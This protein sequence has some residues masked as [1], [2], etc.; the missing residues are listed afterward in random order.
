MKTAADVYAAHVVTELCAR[1]M[2]RPRA[3][4]LVQ[5]HER[6]VRHAFVRG[7]PASYVASKLS[8]TTKSA[9][10]EIVG[11]ASGKARSDMRG[12]AVGSSK[13]SDFKIRRSMLGPAGHAALNADVMVAGKRHGYATGSTECKIDPKWQPAIFGEDLS[14]EALEKLEERMVSKAEYHDFISALKRY[15]RV[16]QYFLNAKKTLS[17]QRMPGALYVE[18]TGNTKVI[19]GPN[20][21]A[22]RKEDKKFAAATYASISSSC[23][24]ECHLRDNGCYAQQG[25]TSMTIK[26]LD[27]EAKEY[28]L[29]S[30]DTAASEAYS[31]FTSHGGGRVDAGGAKGYLRVHV[32]GDSQTVPGTHMIAESVADWIHRGGVQAWCYTHA[33]RKVPRAAWGPISTLASLDDPATEIEAAK[34]QGYVPAI[35]VDSFGPLTTVLPNGR[36]PVLRKDGQVMM[37]KGKVVTEAAYKVEDYD[38]FQRQYLARRAH[39]PWEGD[40]TGTKYIPCPAQVEE[41]VLTKKEY[42]QGVDPKLGEKAGKGCLDCRLCFNDQ[43][44]LRKNNL[45]IMFEAHGPKSKLALTVLNDFRGPRDTGE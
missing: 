5:S 16:H 7:T 24:D 22:R 11:I 36:R 35:V 32:G 20:Y 30:I 9:G 26:R 2:S 28:H 34:A 39:R 15:P 12:Y 1:G 23:P 25:K 14:E 41:F 21:V 6:E 3:V 42:E 19:G 13:A 29:N 31:I 10:K 40:K 18:D 38:A 33:W 44:F 8:R 43:E 45:G 17:R 27:R 4:G 37:K